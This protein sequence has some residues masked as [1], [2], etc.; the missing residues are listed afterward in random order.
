MM[1]IMDT[2]ASTACS[3]SR[4]TWAD[5]LERE[6]RTITMA[7]ASAS[8]PIMDSA[9]SAPGGMSRGAIQQRMPRA[10]RWLRILST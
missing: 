5:W 9:Q 8:A 2:P 7:R 10:S 1:G 4:R 6:E 3:T